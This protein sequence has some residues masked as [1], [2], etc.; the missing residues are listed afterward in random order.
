MSVPPPAAP[1]SYIV[2]NLPISPF[3]FI[4]GARELLVNMS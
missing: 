3:T 2:M 1:L 4:H